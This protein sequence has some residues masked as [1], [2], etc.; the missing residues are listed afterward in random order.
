MA[1]AEVLQRLP[2]AGGVRPEVVLQPLE[3]GLGG[4]VRDVGGVQ[5]D[6]GLSRRHFSLFFY[7]FVH[8]NHKLIV[9]FCI[10]VTVKR[11]NRH[12]IF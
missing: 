9:H 4:V 8:T 11:V 12:Y 6:H 5:G 3:R 1:L 10:F 7:T 2:R